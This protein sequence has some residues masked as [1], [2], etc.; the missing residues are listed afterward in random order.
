MRATFG[1]RQRSPV[2]LYHRVYIALRQ[3]IGDGTYPDGGRLPTEDELALEFGVSRATLRQAVGELVRDGMLSRKQGRGTFVTASGPPA[4]GQRFRGSLAE[5]IS[6]T[7]RST[8]KDVEIAR[9]T[10]IPGRIAEL[11]RLSEP[12]GTVVRRTRLMDD[13]VFAY[14]VNYLPEE[15]GARISETDIRAGSLMQTLQEKGVRLAGGVQ[16]I[17]AQ[18]ADVALGQR[19]DVDFGAPVLFV[20]RLVHGPRRTP[21]ELVHSWYRGDVYEYTVEF[22]LKRRR[23]GIGDQ[24]A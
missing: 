5:L 8:V 16:S 14:T 21:V 2:P 7:R 10:Q 24:L 1:R 19:L 17:H 13:R 6:E 18:V 9:G 3:R 12:T 23:P 15:H 4:V 11:L 22:D 20:E